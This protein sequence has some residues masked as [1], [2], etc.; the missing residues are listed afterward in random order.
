MTKTTCHIHNICKI[1]KNNV[2]Q[3]RGNVNSFFISCDRL[4]HWLLERCNKLASHVYVHV[5]TLLFDKQI[6]FRP[7]NLC[8]GKMAN[9]FF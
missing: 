9:I 2:F 1:K 5:H 7:N 3:F 8:V 6:L 4:Y